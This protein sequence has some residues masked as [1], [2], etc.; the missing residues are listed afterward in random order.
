MNETRVKRKGLTER[1]VAE[2]RAK[3]G[4]NVISSKKRAGFWRHFFANLGDPVIKVLLAALAVN[5]L[6]IL[7]THE[8]FETAGIAISVFLAT[9]ISTI[10][11]YGSEAAFARLCEMCGTT[12]CRVRRES[13]REINVAD[14]VVGDI[15]QLSAGEKIPADGMLVSGTLSVDQS[16]LTGEGREV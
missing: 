6:F 15:V 1:E 2:S 11:E 7:R 9:L 5:L 14:V 12:L 10:S 4:P 13:V 3:Y 16:A 8:W